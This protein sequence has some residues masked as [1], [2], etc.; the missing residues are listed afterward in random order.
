MNAKYF[1]FA[2]LIVLLIGKSCQTRQDSSEWQGDMPDSSRPTPEQIAY[3]QKE[4]IAFVHFGIN[5]FTNQK[6]GT[7]DEDPSL[8]N[9]INFDADQW[10]RFLLQEF[11]AIGQRVAKFSIS[12]PDDT[13]WQPITKE[14]TIGYKRIVRLDKAT[15]SSKLRI[16]FLETT[17]RPAINNIALYSTDTPASNLVKLRIKYSTI[18]SLK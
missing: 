9:P 7:G 16:T 14:T 8:F 5:T 4:R 2:P 11:I 15:T 17:D 3:Q 12:I 1:L 10:T 18:T 13:G 6:W